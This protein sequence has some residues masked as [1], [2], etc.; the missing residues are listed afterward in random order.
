MREICVCQFERVVW[1]R[2]HWT[3]RTCSA[4][5]HERYIIHYSSQTLPMVCMYMCSLILHSCIEFSLSQQ[6]NMHTTDAGDLTN[7]EYPLRPQIR[8]VSLT[9]D[10][11]SIVRSLEITSAQTVTR[12]GLRILS[13]EMKL[14]QKLPIYLCFLY[15][16]CEIVCVQ[17]CSKVIQFDSIILKWLFEQK[18]NKPNQAKKC[19]WKKKHMKM[20]KRKCLD[21]NCCRR[22]VMIFSLFLDFVLNA[23]LKY[24]KMLIVFIIVVATFCSVNKFDVGRS[25]WNMIFADFGFSQL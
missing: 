9:T 14:Y 13:I 7:I 18:K 16:I 6:I 5:T 25:Y 2:T 10:F 3:A 22:N 19:K 11:R 8:F 23:N 20:E 4:H 17:W 21:L 15:N 12:I 24:R 1:M